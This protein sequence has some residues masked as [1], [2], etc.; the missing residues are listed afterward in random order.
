V[1]VNPVSCSGVAFDFERFNDARRCD[2]PVL[3]QFLDLSA[4]H[5]V[6]LDRRRV[7]NVVEP[8]LA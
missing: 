4:G 2:T 6:A 1:P 8:D 7:V 3:H 5:S